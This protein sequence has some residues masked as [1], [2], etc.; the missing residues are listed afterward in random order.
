[1]TLIAPPSPEAAQE[2]FDV[3]KMMEEF[4]NQEFIDFSLQ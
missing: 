2:M 4:E 3:K 1:M